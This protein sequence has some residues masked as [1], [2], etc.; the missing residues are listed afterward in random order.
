MNI[1]STLLWNLV[2]MVLYTSSCHPNMSM[3]SFCSNLVHFDI[4][5]YS[6]LHETTK[7]RSEDEKV[8]QG[9][10]PG[11]YLSSLFL[12][13]W[14]R[15]LFHPCFTGWQKNSQNHQIKRSLTPKHRNILNAMVVPQ[16]FSP[17]VIYHYS[18]FKNHCIVSRIIP[19]IPTILNSIFI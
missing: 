6:H 2:I 8:E 1:M 19:L 17:I 7:R 4:S 15:S 11:K 16:P 5:G 18:G 14:Q 10:R 3:W 12:K 13:P 9:G